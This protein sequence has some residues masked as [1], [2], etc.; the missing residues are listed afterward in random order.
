MNILIDLRT[1]ESVAN[2][3]LKVKGLPYIGLST[4]NNIISYKDPAIDGILTTGNTTIN[5]DLTVTGNLTYNG[6]SSSGNLDAQR[7]TLNKPSNDSETLLNII[8]NNQHCEVIAFESTISGDCCLQNS[9]TAQSSIVW[10]TGIW[11][12]NQY[13][14]RHG[15]H[16]L[17]IYDN[18]DT[19]ISGTLNVGPAQA[20]TSIKAYV[21][22]AGHQ[23]NVEIEARWNTHGYINFN[24]TASDGLLFIATKYVICMYCGLNI[25]CV[26]FYKPTTNVSDDRLKTK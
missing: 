6:D 13:G 19:S 4:T 2:M 26:L 15:V 10:N 16:G 14:I 21:N 22:H 8:N 3:Y 17:W 5:G 11:N 20:T 25:I 1:E 9:K 18:G 24:T 7:L 12:Q 23:G